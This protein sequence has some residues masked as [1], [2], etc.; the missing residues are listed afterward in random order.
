MRDPATFA[1]QIITIDHVSGGRVEAGIGLGLTVDPG[2]QMI[3]VPNWSNPERSARFGEYVEILDQLMTVGRCTFDG[4]YYTVEAAAVHPSVQ[5]PRPPITIAA[6]GPRMMRYA[7]E[8]ADTWNTMSFKAGANDLLAD[9]SSLKDKMSAACEEVGRDPET[10][11][12]SFLLFDADSRASGGRTFYWDRVSAF[13]DVAS[14][15]FGMG[16]DEIGVY[17]PVDS[18]RDV[19]E[20]VAATVMP[21]LREI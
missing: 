14:T 3:G 11:Q 21:G 8:R 4:E 2:Y 18:Q 10:L 12:H 6:M 9:A 15:L 20:A 13:E 1:R 7:A 19:C 5:D 17:Y 16:Y